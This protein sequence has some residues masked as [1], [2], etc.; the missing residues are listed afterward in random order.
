MKMSS[1]GR[2]NRSRAAS[3]LLRFDDE[4]IPINANCFD[5]FPEGGFRLVLFQFLLEA[6]VEA[7]IEGRIERGE[8][9]LGEGA[10]GRL[11]RFGGDDKFPEIV[12][13][14]KTGCAVE[15]AILQSR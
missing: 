6:V 4:F 11:G 5:V 3:V 9:C 10:T 12:G 15:P 1:G 13:E 14:L 2:Q 8:E 7:A